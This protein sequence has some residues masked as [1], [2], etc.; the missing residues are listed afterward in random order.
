M[1]PFYACCD[2]V[3]LTSEDEGLPNVLMEAMAL[4]RPVIGFDVGG[5]RELVGSDGA[6]IVVAWN[7]PAELAAQ[8]QA[9]LAEPERAAALG[10]RGRERIRTQFTQ[11][12]MVERLEAYLGELLAG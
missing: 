4:G 5:V 9:L 6:G 1:A 12:G 10:R 2:V 8:T 11:A 3:L 7:N